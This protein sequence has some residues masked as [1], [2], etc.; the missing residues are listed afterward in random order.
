MVCCPVQVRVIGARYGKWGRDKYGAKPQK[1]DALEFYPD[2]L[3]ELWDRIQEEQ[4]C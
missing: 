1:V 3:R 2:R 4:V